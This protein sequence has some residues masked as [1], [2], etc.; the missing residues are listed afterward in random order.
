MGAYPTQLN[1]LTSLKLVA[2]QIRKLQKLYI[3]A[4][5]ILCLCIFSFTDYKE[6]LE[7]VPG[8]K[9]VTAPNLT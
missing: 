7:H 5:G 3:H 1:Q 6:I 2:G 4:F 9:K 8:T